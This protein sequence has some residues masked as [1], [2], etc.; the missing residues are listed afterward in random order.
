MHK[1]AKPY[2]CINFDTKG[3]LQWQSSPM[4]WHHANEANGVI[5]TRM[6]S[7]FGNGQKGDY[8]T[9]CRLNLTNFA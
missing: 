5:A 7:L 1:K 6:C 8:S 3:V 2:Q 4:Q 9:F